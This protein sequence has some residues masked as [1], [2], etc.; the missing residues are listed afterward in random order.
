M[1]VSMRDADW[2]DNCPPPDANDLPILAYRLLGG[3]EPQEGDFRSWF[4]EGRSIKG[5][6]CEGRGLSVF[7]AIEDARHHIELFGDKSYI[8]V[9]RLMT[10][11]GQLKRTPT[12]KFPQH[13]TWWPDPGLEI[14]AIV[15]LFE[16][17]DEN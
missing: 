1:I 9:A 15:K 6:E 10:N 8:G 2:P 7:T 16:I 11:H 12:G 14:S 4:E 13:A 17:A 5:R 3:P